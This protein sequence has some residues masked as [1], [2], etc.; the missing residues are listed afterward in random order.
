MLLN[1]SLAYSPTNDELAVQLFVPG[2]GG[3]VPVIV[4]F[5]PAAPRARTIATGKPGTAFTMSWSPNGDL[6]A[7]LDTSASPPLL[8]I[9]SPPHSAN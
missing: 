6:L 7:L 9:L 2:P 5:F 3:T 8:T 1:G 4:S